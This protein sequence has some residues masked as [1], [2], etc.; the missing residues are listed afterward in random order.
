MDTEQ[1]FYTFPLPVKFAIITTEG[2]ITSNLLVRCSHL[3][4]NIYISSVDTPQRW[5][6]LPPPVLPPMNDLGLTQEQQQTVDK[7]RRVSAVA[8]AVALAAAPLGNGGGESSVF[9]GNEWDCDGRDQCRKGIDTQIRN[10]NIYPVL[11]NMMKPVLN[12]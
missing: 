1:Y 10:L 8:A 9:W 4:K 5:L 6:T 2:M 7:E 11:E 12:A 3:S